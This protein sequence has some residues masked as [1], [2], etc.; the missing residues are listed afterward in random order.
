MLDGLTSLYPAPTFIR[1]NTGHEFITHALRHWRKSF[2][3]VMVSIES[4]SSWQ[5]GSAESFSSRFS[6]ELL[7]TQLF[8][9]VAETQGLADH[10]SWQYTPSGILR[11][12]RVLCPWSQ[13]RQMQHDHLP[14][15]RLV[16]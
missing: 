12:S 2:R 1:S 5:N 15:L 3:A 13:L 8:A 6:D 7:N 11:P 9:T 10:W 4:E 16:R 14:S